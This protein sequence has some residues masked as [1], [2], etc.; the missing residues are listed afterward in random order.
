MDDIGKIFAHRNAVLFDLDGTVYYGDTLIPGASESIDACRKAGLSVM[1]LTNNSTKTRSQIRG[2]LRGMGVDCA[3]DE[4]MSS[5]FAAASYAAR[6]GLRD[7]FVC[8][9]DDLAR[10]FE[11]LDVPLAIDPPRACNLVIGY[12]PRFDYSKLTCAVRVAMQAETVIACNRERTYAGKDA[13]AFPG[14]GGMVAPIEWCSGHAVDYV[15]GKPN[16]RMV[17]IAC[18]LAGCDPVHAVMVGDTYESDI[19]MAQDAGCGCVLV[20]AAHGRDVAA[21]GSIAEIA[22]AVVRYG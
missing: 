20:G 13:Q 1:F 11:D 7:V 9:S 16:A 19:V 5:G 21:V 18:E 10:E 22:G 12:D 17:E 3:L 8:G 4:V 2:R 6:M 14:C 15:V